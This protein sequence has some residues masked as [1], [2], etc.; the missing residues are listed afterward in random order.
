[1]IPQVTVGET[2]YNEIGGYPGAVLSDIS[3]EMLIKQ[4]Q[5]NMNGE[6]VE[7]ASLSEVD[8]QTSS[9]VCFESS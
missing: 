1:M 5:L 4:L 9:N 6:K 3:D 8:Y 7:L 2:S